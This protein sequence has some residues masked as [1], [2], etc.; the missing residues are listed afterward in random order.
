MVEKALI[1]ILNDQ[2]Q[3]DLPPVKSG[4]EL[5]A[6]L[7]EI[8]NHLIQKDFQKL[9]YILYKVDVSEIKL[10]Q[11]LQ[12]DSDENTSV[13]ISKL[14]IERQLQKLESRKKITSSNNIS[15]EEKW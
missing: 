9:V 13:I 8:I 1:K 12:A 5:E 6:T 14:I 7:S 11:M 2:L 15:E 3:I 4:K 10:K